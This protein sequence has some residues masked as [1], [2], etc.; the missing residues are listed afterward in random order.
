MLS[1]SPRIFLVEKLLTLGQCEHLMISAQ[2][3]G[4]HPHLG[5]KA[6]GT[7]LQPSDSEILNLIYM[8]IAEVPSA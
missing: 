5:L 4:L 7:V 2:R 3:K 8:Q 6:K 1:E